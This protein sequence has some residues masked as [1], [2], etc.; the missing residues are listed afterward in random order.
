MEGGGHNI[1]LPHY[2]GIAAFGREY[3]D[4]LANARDLRGPDKDHFSGSSLKQAFTNGAVQLAAVGVAANGDV[5]CTKAG[6]GRVF[7]ILGKKDR[8]GAGP[9]SWFQ[10]DEL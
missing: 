3:F 10:P 5:N 9:K 7:H 1:S 2:N 6:L 8:A 4:P